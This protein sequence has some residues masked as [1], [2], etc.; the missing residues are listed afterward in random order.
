MSL[1]VDTENKLAPKA[2]RLAFAPLLAL[3]RPH[4]WIK[5]TFVAAPLFFSPPAVSLHAAS[6]IAAGVVS[7]CLLASAVY[8]FNDYKDRVA[9]R[10]HPSK[11]YRPLA[12]GTVS[13]TQA[14][15]LFVVLFLSGFVLAAFLEPIF[16]SFAATYVTI[17]LAY[18]LG[19][20]RVAIIDVL[21]IS[22]LFILRVY[23]GAVLIGLI[24]SPWMI[25]CVG[26]LALFIALA[27]R[28]DDLEIGLD[29]SHRV[30]L[31]GYT[32]EFLDTATAIVLGALLIAYL[33]YTT[34]DYAKQKF[35]TEWLYLTTPFVIA[36]VLRYLQI[37]LVERRSG[38]PTRLVLKDRFLKV[39][40]LGWLMTFGILIY[41]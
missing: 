22:A 12:A 10:Q 2:S 21:I 25:V 36:G 6:M 17:N 4:Q 9:D 16:L 40:I 32:K 38:A 26:L 24:P 7:F 35:E 30:S 33:I 23:A 1:V 37:T 13:T 8:I 41:G 5:N 28:R 15:G 34:G 27:K 29:N 39:T 31:E 3:M 11:R 20:K 19:L 18:S 14:A